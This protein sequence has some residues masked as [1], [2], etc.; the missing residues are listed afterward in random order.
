MSKMHKSARIHVVLLPFIACLLTINSIQANLSSLAKNDAYPMFSSLDPATFLLGYEK[1]KYRNIEWAKEKGRYAI[2]AISPFAQN[3]DKGKPI[4]GQSSI[5]GLCKEDN[6]TDCS[7]ALGDLTGR[8][9]MIALIYGPLP[10]GVNQWTSTLQTARENLFPDQVMTDPNAVLDDPMKIDTN[11]DFGYFSFPLKYRK[12]GVRFD[13]YLQFWDDIGINIQTGVSSIR[14]TIQKRINLT[15][16]VVDPETQFGLTR[17]QV[18]TNLMEPFEN[19]AQEIDLDV[20]NF[21]QN[22]I[23]EIRLSLYWRHAYEINKNKYDFPYLL[24]IPYLEIGGSTSPGKKKNPNKF[25]GLPF[26]NNEHASVGLTGGIDFDFIESIEVGGEV[27]FTHFFDKSFSNFR[28][29]TNKFQTTIFPFTTDV[30][31]S[32]G[33]NW[34]F[35]GKITAY[36]FLDKLSMYFQYVL[37]EHKDDDIKLKRSDPTFLP[38]VLEKTTGWKTKLANIGFNYDISPNLLLGFLWQAPLSQ[39]NTYRSTTI[40]FTFNATF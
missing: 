11:Q 20:C 35:A 16:E 17:T 10:E 34:H 25:F 12:R 7:D 18:N 3:A 1:L 13:I 14:Q 4:E 32:P 39:R 5:E 22:S 38:K 9:G 26:G 21:Q 2:L 40:L 19:I 33:R 28:V 30:K 8:T 31:I 24:V 36:H 37:I 23:E 29:P 15:D 6:I 27:G